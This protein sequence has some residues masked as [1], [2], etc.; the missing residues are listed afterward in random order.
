MSEIR[1]W[2]NGAAWLAEFETGAD[3]MDSL[4]GGWLDA[5]PE[6]AE[7]GCAAVRAGVEPLAQDLRTGELGRGV[8]TV[9]LHARD[10]EVEA[11]GEP[12]EAVAGEHFGGID[13]GDWGIR[14]GEDPD[15]RWEGIDAEPDYDGVDE[16][17]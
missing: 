8:V 7:E 11:F 10:L 2:T 14:G 4:E 13:K 17:P 9:V 3:A 16:A 12:I 15:S 5:Q 1:T 6:L